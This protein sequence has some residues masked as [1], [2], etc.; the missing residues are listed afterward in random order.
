MPSKRRR[1]VASLLSCCTPLLLAGAPALVVWAAPAPVRADVNNVEPYM[2]VIA[3]SEAPMRCGDSGTYYPVATLKAGTLLRVDGESPQWVRVVYPAGQ[4]AFVKPDEAS[5]DSAGKTVRLVK[6]SRLYAS[7]AAVGYRGSFFPLLARELPAGT[8]LSVVEVVKSD[9][10]KVAMYAVA[11][12]AESRGYITRDAIRRATA[13][14]IEAAGGA[15]PAPITPGDPTKAPAPA[16]APAPQPKAPQ[17]QPAV[18][19]PVQPQPQPAPAQPAT[20]DPTKAPAPSPAPQPGDGTTVIVPGQPEAGQPVA[21]AQPATQPPEPPKPTPSELL[22]AVYDRVKGQAMLEAE[23]DEAL[24]EF[25]KY[26]RTLGDTPADAATRRNLDR[27]VQ[28]LKLR[29][30]VRETYRANEAAQASLKGRESEVGKQ[31]AE[32]ERQRV[33]NVIGRLVASTVYDGQRLPLMYRIQSPEPAMART[34][35]YLIPDPKMDLSGKVGQIVG[36]LGDSRFDD[37]LKANL[38]VARKVDVIS[39]APIT[40]APPAAPASTGGTPPAPA[41]KPAPATPGEPMQEMRPVGE[42]PA[43]PEKP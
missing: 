33:Y 9:D 16:P 29:R 42:R 32:M 13:Q 22:I 38:Y 14:E 30:E 12:P 19:A 40:S 24:A 8:E 6:P 37:A 26:M 10:G 39:L 4:K 35:G 17:P 21:P 2:V 34:L 28:V 7:N 27:Y 11:A 36:V 41:P 23:I 3:V 31:V 5:A 15:K 20:T 18:P 25:D 43:A 1:S